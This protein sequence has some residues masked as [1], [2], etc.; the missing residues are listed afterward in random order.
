MHV[1][2]L[3]FSGETPEGKILKL[4]LG[5]L[6]FSLQQRLLLV[7]LG[8]EVWIF[9]FIW[10]FF[11][12]EKWEICLIK[13]HCI[14]FMCLHSVIHIQHIFCHLWACCAFIEDYLWAWSVVFAPTNC[15]STEKCA[16]VCAHVVVQVCSLCSRR[17]TLM[18]TGKCGNVGRQSMLG[19]CKP[20]VEMINIHAFPK[21][22]PTTSPPT[23]LFSPSV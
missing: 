6:L 22:S 11:V 12:V 21:W 18:S 19:Y 2:S 1:L 5:C 9:G 7:N 10:S 20:V 23:H 15:Y 4:V 16:Y 8:G 17:R 3:P 13:S 14:H